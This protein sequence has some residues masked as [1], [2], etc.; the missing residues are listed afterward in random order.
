[1]QALE[2]E[3]GYALF[4]RHGLCVA[5]TAQGFLLHEDAERILASLRQIHLRRGIARG[6]AQ[7]LL[8]ATSALALACCRTP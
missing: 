6:D 4:T 1:V 5:P 2:A 7:L 8:A 3:I